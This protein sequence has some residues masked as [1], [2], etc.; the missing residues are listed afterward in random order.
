MSDPTLSRLVGQLSSLP[1]KVTTII[2]P[3]SKDAP[4]F[5]VA[6]DDG[7]LHP[8]GFS[9]AD[10]AQKAK[11]GI[12][13]WT[14]PIKRTTG[15]IDLRPFLEHFDPQTTYLNFRYE[16]KP[17]EDTLQKDPNARAAWDAYERETKRFVEDNRKTSN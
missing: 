16:V 3:F 1:V 9:L 11:D 2:T 12:L 15:R 13:E 7:M 14:E 10:L 6:R 8:M 4:R 5:Q 17:D